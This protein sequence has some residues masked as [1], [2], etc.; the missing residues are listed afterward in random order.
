M[1]LAQERGVLRARSLQGG[2]LE[3]EMSAS[4]AHDPCLA[5]A[6]VF[7]HEK[8]ISTKHKQSRVISHDA[9]V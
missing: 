9:R 6:L 2:L 3:G 7:K 5:L 4:P 1:E 8:T